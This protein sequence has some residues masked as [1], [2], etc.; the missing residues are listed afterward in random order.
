MNWRREHLFTDGGLVHGGERGRRFR[1]SGTEG[2][3]RKILG[4]D[5]Y[6]GTSGVLREGL[7]RSD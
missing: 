6:R 3:I 5:S 4:L 7:D 1:V 2:L